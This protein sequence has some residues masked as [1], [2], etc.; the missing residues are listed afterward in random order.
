VSL[1]GAYVRINTG[2]S[3]PRGISVLAIQMAHL[4]GC[5]LRNGFMTTILMLVPFAV[6]VQVSLTI[7]EAQEGSFINDFLLSND[8]SDENVFKL[9]AYLNERAPR[10]LA[11]LDDDD[12]RKFFTRS[13]FTGAVTKCNRYNADEFLVLLGDAAHSVIPPTGEGACMW[14]GEGG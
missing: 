9:K 14:R 4:N 5:T 7:K 10:M 6:G 1:L 2:V 3:L 12:Y 8:P 11:I 13:T